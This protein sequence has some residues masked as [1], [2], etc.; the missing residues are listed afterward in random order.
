VA[1]R[2]FQAPCDAMPLRY[3]DKPIGPHLAEQGGADG[4]C[5]VGLKLLDR[6]LG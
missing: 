4:Q 6:H 3:D 2:F 5:E 1:G